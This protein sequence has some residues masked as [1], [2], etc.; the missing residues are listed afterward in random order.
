MLAVL[1]SRVT[2]GA[3]PDEK[4]SR[5]P[6]WQAPKLTLG[7]EEQQQQQQQHNAREQKPHGGRVARYN[8][9]RDKRSCL[10]F[11]DSL[12]VIYCVERFY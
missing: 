8:S 11:Q 2:V 4:V 3:A 12:K 7:A 10:E 9:T 1:M 6:D 5:P